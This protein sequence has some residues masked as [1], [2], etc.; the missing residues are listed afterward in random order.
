[1]AE[2][3]DFSMVAPT[4]VQMVV[5]MAVRT[6]CA[7]VVETVG[8]SVVPK[9]KRLAERSAG[10]TGDRSEVALGAPSVAWKVSMP[11]AP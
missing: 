10:E 6:E 3:K 9:E 7:K 11:V 2:L 8:S 1:M 4:A 5:L